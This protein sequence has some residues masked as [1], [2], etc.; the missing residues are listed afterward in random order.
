M[1]YSDVNISNMAL[2]LCGAAP[3]RDFTETNKRSRMCQ[4]LFEPT[5][6]LLLS[7]FD[8]PFA[9][10]YATLNQLDLT[11]QPIPF[12]SY[13][14]QLPNNCLTPRDIYPKGSR[15]KWIV[16]GDALY[17]IQTS[18]GLYFTAQVTDISSVSDTFAH[19]LAQAIAIKIAPAITQDKKLTAVLA[20]QYK[21]MQSEVWESEA[22]VG[23]DYREYDDDPDNDTFVNPNIATELE[24][25]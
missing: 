20:N 5:K 8:W 24:T 14:Y 3:F 15:D 2:A 18:V 10:R 17:T 16:M 1:A 11:G 4:T 19:L 9:R 22:N 21:S 23:N 25:T 7:K 12:G 6:N 13:G